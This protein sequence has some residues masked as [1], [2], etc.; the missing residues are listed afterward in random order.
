MT[1][2]VIIVAAGSSKRLGGKV[3]K[4]YLNIKG[5]PALYYSIK[6]FLSLNMIKEV[7]VVIREKDETMFRSLLNKY[8]FFGVKYTYGGKERKDSVLN[9]LNALE[10]K[11]GIVLIHDA[12]RPFVS[13]EQFPFYF[14]E[15]L[16]R[17]IRN[18]FSPY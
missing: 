6:T 10:N 3:N 8:I 16:T 17:L 1:I 15:H 13:K 14:R 9:G 2:S 12:A 11:K 18:L 5:K 4:P 7:L